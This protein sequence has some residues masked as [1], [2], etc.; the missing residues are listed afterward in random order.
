[1]FGWFK[2]KRPETTKEKTRFDVKFFPQGSGHDFLCD[3]YELNGALSAID[4]VDFITSKS[5]DHPKHK[6]LATLDWFGQASYTSIHAIHSYD[7]DEI[8][9][10][11]ISNLDPE[12]FE[13]GEHKGYFSTKS[14]FSIRLDN[15]KQKLAGIDIESL[16]GS[17]RWK[18]L[19]QEIDIAA[20][21]INK[22]YELDKA[23]YVQIVP[24]MNSADAIAAFPNGYFSGDLSPMQNHTLAHYLSE[25][26]GYE[27]FGIGASYLGFV[28]QDKLEGATLE[29]MHA[30]LSTLFDQPDAESLDNML[31]NERILLLPYTGNG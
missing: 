9:G 2:K 28:R 11:D 18:D 8:E 19:D 24:V 27:L 30:L 7:L 16:Q 3:A 17:L 31:K 5:A 22:E 21:N 25:N 14:E 13:D 4:I 23:S 12:A 15:L 1:M 10:H 29:R 20:V 26:F 6:L